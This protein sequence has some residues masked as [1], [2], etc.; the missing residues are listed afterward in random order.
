MQVHNSLPFKMQD[1]INA[2]IRSPI[3]SPI[4]TKLATSTDGSML[5]YDDMIVEHNESTATPKQNL[6]FNESFVK[7]NKNF[8]NQLPMMQTEYNSLFDS[9]GSRFTVKLND[10]RLLRLNINEMTTCHLV[11]MCLEAFKSTLNKDI[12]YE[13]VQQW[14]IHRCTISDSINDQLNLFLYLIINLCGCFDMHQLEVEMPSLFS[15]QTSSHHIS[16]SDHLKNDQCS[17]TTVFDATANTTDS[18][19]SSSMTTLNAK[20]AKCNTNGDYKFV[21]EPAFI[22]GC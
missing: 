2:T 13:I 21:F 17:N 5:V 14:F 20:R 6:N 19:S 11:K 22:M 3:I 9:S 7:P 12:Y 15:F 16:K 4:K 10:N 18:S 1:V 8:L